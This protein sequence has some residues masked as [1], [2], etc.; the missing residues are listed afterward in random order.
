MS[1]RRFM[2]LL[3]NL[4]G[5]SVFMTGHFFENHPNGDPNIITDPDIAKQTMTQW[6]KG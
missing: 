1:Y 5:D 3:S 2:V 4:S 6:A